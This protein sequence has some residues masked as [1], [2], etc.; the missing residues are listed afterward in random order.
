MSYIVI[1]IINYL[2][3]NIVKIAAQS[4]IDH[5]YIIIQML[6]YYCSTSILAFFMTFSEPSGEALSVSFFAMAGMSIYKYICI[7]KHY[8][9]SK[10]SF[11][12]LM[13]KYYYLL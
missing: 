6:V 3:D 13:F 2:G 7:C 1:F 10:Y 5:K 9:I 8:Y 4:V 11:N 12:K